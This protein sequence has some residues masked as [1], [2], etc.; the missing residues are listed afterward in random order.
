MMKTWFKIFLSGVVCALITFKVHAGEIKLVE[1]VP[2]E[3]VY[4]SKYALNTTDV[5]LEMINKA[6]KSIDMEQFYIANMPGE[7]LEA[8]LNAIKEAAER[9]VK[10]RVI[11]DSMMM[12]ES[13]V[14]VEPLKSVANFEVRVM[15]FKK[16]A[17]GVQ[18]AKFFI[19][20]DKEVFVGSQNFDWRALKHIH[21]LGVRIKSERA[22]KTFKT[23][24]E[25]DWKVSAADD[26]KTA[27]EIFHKM[28]FNPVTKKSPE[29][30]MFNGSP[31]SYYLA[32]SPQK[33]KPP[34]FNSEIDEILGLIEKAKKTILIQVMTYSI[35]DYD[36]TRWNELNDALEQAAKRGVNIKMVLADW[37]MGK[38]T[39]KDIKNLSKI[40]NIKIKI[41]SIPEYTGGFIPFSRVEHCKY[42]VVDD[43]TA[44]IST[45]NWS[46]SY[47]YSSRDAAVIMKGKTA[48]DAVKDVF[49]KAWNGPYV[50]LVDTEKEY[51]PVQRQ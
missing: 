9:S 41:S 30:A 29:K 17:G 42:M 50:R 14:S 45:S 18:H 11:V 34:K 24:F 26:T 35:L 15:D 28:D 46:K 19:V 43:K 36:N 20:D 27:E 4:G 1:S 38:K 44:L 5:W 7:P 13:S 25:H 40:P 47:F 33:L 37:T 16:L 21:E 32:F 3:T 51:Q 10:I 8:V 31:I 12:K 49:Q 48:A 22:A 39:D 23:I 2:D 6:V